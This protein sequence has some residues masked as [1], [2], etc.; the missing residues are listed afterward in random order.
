MRLLKEMLLVCCGLLALAGSPTASAGDDTT[1]TDTFRKGTAEW[2]S[3]Y[4]AADVDR[5]LAL[6][7]ADA[8]VMPPDAPA[9]SGHAAIRAFLG[10]DMAS[11]KAAG[12]TLAITDGDAGT[13]G[14]LG[15]HDG[16][17]S[18]RDAGGN[19]VGTGKYLEVWERKAGKWLIVRDIWNN[20]SA[21]APAAA[22]D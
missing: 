8:V 14:N 9:A 16:T 11:S 12:I 22:A 5:V 6:Y 10:K 18:V 2:V 15:W 4:N 13:S 7:A 20:D 19:S 17:Y 1:A 3:A 21:A